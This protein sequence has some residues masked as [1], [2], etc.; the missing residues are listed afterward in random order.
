MANPDL[1]WESTTQYN[2]GIDLGLFKERIILNADYYMKKTTDMLLLAPVSS[3]S[4]YNQQWKNIG[5]V[6]NKGLELMLTTYNIDKKDF[7]WNTSV[8]F[9]LPRNEVVDLGPGVDFIPVTIYGGFFQNVGRVV[10]GESIGTA[11][12]FVWDGIYQISDFTWQN[13][14]DPTIAHDQRT[15]TL[16]PEVVRVAG[17]SVKPGSFK[18]RDLNGDNVVDDAKDRKVISHSFPKHFGGI[19]NNLT[20]KNFE[21]GIFVDWSYGNEILNESR[22]LSEGTQGW[23]NLRKDFWDNRWTP[24]NPTNEYGTISAKNITSAFISSYY[25]EDGSFIRLK[26]VNLAYNVPTGLIGKIGFSDVKIYLNGSNLYTFT[27]Y[28]GFDPEIT[29]NNQLLPGFDR[30]SYPKARTITIGIQASF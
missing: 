25:V 20:Y 9:S 28:S 21:L 18:F 11:Y 6:D 8:N 17:S 15:Y 5:R 23:M 13:N 29:F 12:G 7:K 22:Y 2:G 4:G 1:K 26:N 14:S 3:Q 27:N 24:D 19:N 10:K 16:K 30:Y